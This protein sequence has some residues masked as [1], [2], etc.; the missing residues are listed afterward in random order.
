[1]EYYG[2][3]S[4]DGRFQLLSEHLRMNMNM[5]LMQSYM[6]HY[7]YATTQEKKNVYI[8]NY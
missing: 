5:N 7:R 2:H 4:E 8:K 3:S 6:L 1:M